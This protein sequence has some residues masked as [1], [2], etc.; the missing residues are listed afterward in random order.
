MARLPQPGGDAG[1]WGGILNDYLSQ[2]HAEDGTLKTDTVGAPQLKPNAV[3]TAAISNGS[4]TS[5]K[6]QGIGQANGIATLDAD[7]RLPEAQLPERLTEAN[8]DATIE[9]IGDS[10]FAQRLRRVDLPSWS[11]RA[12]YIH[13]EP[14]TVSVSAH[15]GAVAVSSPIVVGLDDPRIYTT[16]LVYPSSSGSASTTD[17]SGAVVTDSYQRNSNAGTELLP[18]AIEFVTDSTSFEIVYQ[19]SSAVNYKLFEDGLPHTLAPIQITSGGGGTY[20]MRVRPTARKLRRFR[21]EIVSMFPAHLVFGRTDTVYAPP[22]NRQIVGFVGDSYMQQN[23]SEIAGTVADLLGWEAVVDGDGGSGYLSAPTFRTRLPGILATNPDALVIC[24]GINDS[25]S[26]LDVELSAY[27]D[28]I[29]AAR[30]DMPVFVCGPWAPSD[31][32]RSSQTSKFGLIKT[33]AEAH[34]FVFLDNFTTPWITGT[35]TEAAPAGDGNADIMTAT[36]G[37]HVNSTG[38]IYLA[39]RLAEA[40]NRNLPSV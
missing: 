32:S 16:P 35:G 21:I 7:V 11:A 17:Y 34:G 13:P 36:D 4:V 29:V 15:N 19:A 2:S 38:R 40:I 5:A 18:W 10:R 8:L 39:T 30:P 3:T 33:A 26:G 1:N 14:S 9:A 12:G 6:I 24:G 22:A 20:R 27:F 28:A 31:V 25:T 37:T 23:S